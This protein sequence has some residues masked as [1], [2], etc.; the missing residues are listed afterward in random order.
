MSVTKFRTTVEE[1]FLGVRYFILSL[2]SSGHGYLGLEVSGREKDHPESNVFGGSPNL[3]S[4]LFTHLVLLRSSGVLYD[5][6]RSWT[7]RSGNRSLDYK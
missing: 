6:S 5:L 3:G 7:F 2:R 1:D 4:G